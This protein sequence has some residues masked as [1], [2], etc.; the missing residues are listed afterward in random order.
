MVE[1]PTFGVVQWCD[2]PGAVN[3]I[4]ETF[5]R[6]DPLPMAEMGCHWVPAFMPIPGK[7]LEIVHEY[8]LFGNMYY[9]VKI[10]LQGNFEKKDNT[11]YTLI[12]GPL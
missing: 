11:G 1:L 12:K 5:K 4:V 6:P 7:V 2:T 8:F 9:L 10:E 3:E